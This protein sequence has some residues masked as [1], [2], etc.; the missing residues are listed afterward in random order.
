MVPARPVTS[1]MSGSLYDPETDT[2]TTISRGP[3]GEA[4]TT[5]EGNTL[6]R[7]RDMQP[8]TSSGRMSGSLYD[9]ETNTT[10]TIIRGPNGSVRTVEQGNTLGRR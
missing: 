5:E 9:P 3:N 8:R 4:R 6:D 2:T 1:R 7:H 10:T